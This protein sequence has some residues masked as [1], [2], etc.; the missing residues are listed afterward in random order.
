[1]LVHN[2]AT[3]G[4][5]QHDDLALI[6]FGGFP[7]DVEVHIDLAHAIGDIPFGLKSRRLFQ[8]ILRHGRQLEFTHDH[9]LTAHS[10]DDPAGLDSRLG[11]DLPDGQPETLWLNHRALFDCP[12]RRLGKTGMYDPVLSASRSQLYDLDGVAA[13]V[14]PHEA[15][16]AKQCHA[17]VSSRTCVWAGALGYSS[18]RSR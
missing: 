17:V 18:H 8:L 13:D 16:R 4:D 15:F 9:G 14:E 11:D 6:V 10:R 5:E 12:G 7:D 3:G 1:M 2:I